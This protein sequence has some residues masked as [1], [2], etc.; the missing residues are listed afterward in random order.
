[1]VPVC[2]CHQIVT[3]ITVKTSHH[4]QQ[5]VLPLL[6]YVPV[7]LVHA[8]V[9][10][11]YHK[12]VRMQFLKH[13]TPK[14][15]GDIINMASLFSTVSCNVPGTKDYMQFTFC[16]ADDSLLPLLGVS[17]CYLV[18]VNLRSLSKIPGPTLLVRTIPPCRDQSIKHWLLCA[19]DCTDGWWYCT[20]R[21][22]P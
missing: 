20:E 14:T 16:L 8:H 12:R 4:F 18:G 21:F 6:L 3:V 13:M 19:R 2:L 5:L 1:M 7:G 17:S 10:R 11:Q 22:L 15:A 9:I